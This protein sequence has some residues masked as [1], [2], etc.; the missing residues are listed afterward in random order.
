MVSEKELAKLLISNGL[1]KN[2][3]VWKT[4]FVSYLENKKTTTDN[5]TLGEDEWR[6]NKNSS[7]REMIMHLNNKTLQKVISLVITDGEE[8]WNHL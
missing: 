4:R 1:P 7:H 2:F 6:K 5:N 8:A 3:L